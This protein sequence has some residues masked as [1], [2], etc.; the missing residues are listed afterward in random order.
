MRLTSDQI[1]AGLTQ[2]GVPEHTAQ[3]V[4]MNFADESGLETGMQE[5]EP[6][7]GRGG[8]GLAQ[9]T[10]PRREALEQYAAAQG[11]AID[12][13]DMQ[14]DFFMKENASSEADAWQQVLTAPTA[15]E[16]AVSFLKNWER[17]APEHQA[18]RAAKYGAQMAGD[19]QFVSEAEVPFHINEA[20]RDTPRID[21]PKDDV[22]DW[23]QTQRDAW[24]QNSTLAL[25]M[26]HNPYK[27]DPSWQ[28]P[29]EAKLTADLAKANLDPERYAKFL[30][31]S[32][33]QAGY[34]KS[35]QNA[36]ADRDRLER[37]SRAGFKGVLLDFVN[38]TLDPVNIAT[39]IAVSTMVPELTLAKYGART[40]R[41][42]SAAL[43][44]GASGLATTAVNYGFNP[45][46][47]KA[48]LLM[49]T[50]MGMG[51]GAVVGRLQRN[52]ATFREASNL[53]QLA[54]KV[55]AEHEG[56]PYVAPRTGKGST[57]AAAVNH[58]SILNDDDAFAMLEHD[59]VA[60]S[61]FAGA[62]GDL[63][64]RGDR[65]ANPGTRGIMGVLVQDGTGKLGD[66][67]NGRA[68]SEDAAMLVQEW[69]GKFA[70]SWKPQKDSFLAKGNT[71]DQFDTAVYRYVND[72]S[73]TRDDVYPEEVV[74]AGK[75]LIGLFR[76]QL[77]LAK[78]PLLREGGTGRA[79]AGAA[80]TSVSDH[81]L[82]REWAVERIHLANQHF[83]DGTIFD[84][85]KGGMRKANADIDEKDLDAL[86]GAMVKSLVSRG[87]GID[88][89]D[90]L[91][92]VSSV[93]MEEAMAALVDSKSL[94]Q[95]Q[96][97]KIMANIAAK[98]A[99]NKSDASHAQPFKRRTLIDTDYVL[100]Y[101]PMLA[102]GTAHD[103]ELGIVDLLNTNVEYLTTKYT[104][105]QAGNI[106]LA[107]MKLRVPDRVDAEGNATGDGFTIFD[108]ITNDREWADLL[109]RNARKGADM[110]LS[111]QEI[112]MDT[113]RLQFA[114]DSIKGKKTYDFNSTTAGWALRM[115]RKFNFVRMM[116]QVGLAQLPELGNLVGSVGLKAMIQQLPNMRR[117]VGADGIAHL[118]NGF[119]DDVEAVFGNGL[120]GWTRTPAERYDQ[121]MDT[122]QNT[123]GGSW[124]QKIERLLDRG[125]R[126]TSKISGM[127]G[128]DTMSKRWAYKAVIQRFANEAHGRGG[129][130]KIS[131]KRLAD[132]GLS[133]EMYGRVKAE[134]VRPEGV[135]M[136]GKRVAGLKLDQWKDAE[137]AEAFRRAVYRKSSEIIQKNDLGN[138]IM[139]MSHPIGQTLMQFRSF[140]AAAYVKQTLKSLHMRDPEAF[141]NASMAMFIGAMVY[142]VQTRE[143]AIGRSDKEQFL[144]DR[145]TWDKIV[146][147]GFAKAGVS[148]ILPMLVDTALPAFGYK[149][150]FS[151]SRTTGQASDL[152]LGNPGSGL[153]NDTAKAAS[154][155]R[156]VAHGD[157]S[158]EELRAIMKLSP[159]G[160]A[161]G[162]MQFH[163]FAIS[164][165]RE[166]T[167]SDRRQPVGLF[168]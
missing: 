120:E 140:M 164:G 58:S 24:N 85:I 106:A 10:G 1:V 9:W 141:I 158:Q 83:A 72:K 50:V 139:W 129:L 31:G 107:R 33:S 113:K 96:A 89:N 162:F 145:L 126:I 136:N 154:A 92:K 160:N 110:G 165:L 76:D 65:S 59:D 28:K 94:T 19:T 48:D 18:T 167:P 99:M 66:N 62:R 86:A 101:R 61:A 45:N 98:R 138:T 112:A 125:A 67:I 105:R 34:M 100:P 151:Y 123:K 55:V 21:P 115:V 97:D 82:P 84:L 137:A 44:G 131:D 153:V 132:L 73:S 43:A 103:S 6:T 54:H 124:Q 78:N 35:I 122:I 53:Q 3:G 75:S 70:R 148:S 79:V 37:L 109:A 23:W 16:A 63:A 71:E 88:H 52:P 149:P 32:T 26:N 36:Q 25:I 146:S 134:L 144:R 49:G 133:K 118:K 168:D 161:F 7:S 41:V 4:A 69:E 152:L 17:P 12:D 81:Y 8:F 22:P 116:N 93:D 64:A 77:A 95:A 68:A 13:A 29:D 157:P 51:V 121:L 166:R 119:G 104:R 87:A 159:F 2:R 114:Y 14:L 127:E 38:Q 27:A 56:V 135:Q 80:E 74:K 143:Q 147:A 150:Q 91:A 39:D 156:G 15:N 117:V 155:L 130:L 20:V 60:R 11:K 108:G 111:P 47:T 30:G 142:E 40:G 57:G 46:A 102:D 42:L 163:N 5:H 90:F 128:I